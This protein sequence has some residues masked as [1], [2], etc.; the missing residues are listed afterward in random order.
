MPEQSHDT[1][2]MLQC[3]FPSQVSLYVSPS[4]YF[5][6]LGGINILKYERPMGLPLRQVKCPVLK[7]GCP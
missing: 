5:F 3:T 7:V 2:T 1:S 4:T 6:S